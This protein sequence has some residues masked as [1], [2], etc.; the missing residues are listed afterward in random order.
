[1]GNYLLLNA[2]DRLCW[3][4]EESGGPAAGLVRSLFG[5]GLVLDAPDVPTWFFA[6]MLARLAGPA[7]PHALRVG[8]G[9]TAPE[10]QHACTCLGKERKKNQQT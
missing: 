7:A 5:G 10:R 2:L 9:A 3:L 8:R 4:G 6:D 1:M